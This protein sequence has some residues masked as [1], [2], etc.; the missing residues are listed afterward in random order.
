M[1]EGVHE[2]GQSSGA[3]GTSGTKASPHGESA[4]GV[5]TDD[6][7]WRVQGTVRGG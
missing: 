4:P 5:I 3:L 7:E 2:D 1:A 6:A